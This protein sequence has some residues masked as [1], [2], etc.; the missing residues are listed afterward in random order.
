MSFFQK[1]KVKR[2][3]SVGLV[4]VRGRI[5]KGYGRVYRVVEILCVH[6]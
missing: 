6:V 5:K 1:W 4:P 2:V 3:L